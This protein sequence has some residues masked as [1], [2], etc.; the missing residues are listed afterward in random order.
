MPLAVVIRSGTTPSC[1][2]ANQSPVRQ[3]PLWISSAMNRIPCCAHQSA[4]RLRYPAGGTMKPPSPWIG[5]MSTAAVFCSP[6]W[7][8]TCE[9]NAANAS[10]AQRS[11]PVGQR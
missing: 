4:I 6:T 11:G 7:V 1:S 3:K 9:T 2:Q 8:C 5:S 10:S